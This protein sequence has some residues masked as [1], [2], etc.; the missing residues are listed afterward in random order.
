ME[1]DGGVLCWGHSLLRFGGWIMG[2]MGPVENLA[3]GETERFAS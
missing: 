1:F 2:G 3:R